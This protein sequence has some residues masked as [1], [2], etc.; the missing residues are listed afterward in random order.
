MRNENTLH[1]LSFISQSLVSTWNNLEFLDLKSFLPR[2]SVGGRRD[3]RNG[4]KDDEIFTKIYLVMR[5]GIPF[6]ISTFF[7]HNPCLTHLIR[8][9]CNTVFLISLSLSL[10]YHDSILHTIIIIISCSSFK[11]SEPRIPYLL[12]TCY[13]L[14][15]SYSYLPIHHLLLR[16]ERNSC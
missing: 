4:R 7:F 3:D 8:F 15:L 16:A 9:P 12:Y 10:S 13:L 6:P 1:E 2:L 11:V 14:I 5:K